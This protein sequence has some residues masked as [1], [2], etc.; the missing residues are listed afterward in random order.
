MALPAGTRLG[1][2]EILS[3]LGSGGMGEVYKARDTRLDRTVAIKVLPALSQANADV[4]ERFEREARVLASLDHPHIC[5]LHDVGNQG[6]VDFLVMPFLT[7]DTL[8]DRLA[9]GPLPIA[10]AIQT[11]TEIADALDR[12]HS[13]GIVHRDLKPGNI[14]LTGSGAKLLDFGLAR[15]DAPAS[16]ERADEART[17]PAL[18]R[19]GTVMGTLP[20]MSP[21]QLTAAPV[22]ARADIW[23][24]GCVLYEMITGRLPFGGD[25]DAAM[26]SAILT[27]EPASVATLAPRAP[28]ALDAVIAGAL[29]KDPDAR[30]QSARDVRR[31]LAMADSRSSETGPMPAHGG[32]WRR[33]ALPIA[34]LLALALGGAAW[35][36]PRRVPPPSPVRFDVSPAG[37]G[38]IPTFTD[39]RPYFAAAP[40]GRQI[41]FV[42]TADGRTDLWVKRLDAEKAERL[43][44]TQN[45]GAPFWSPDGR[46]IAFLANG[47]LKRKGLDGGTAQT[48]CETDAQGINASWNTSG[49][50]LFAEWGTRRI[51]RVPEHGGTPVVVREGENPFGWVQFLPD[52]RHFLYSVV[53]LGTSISHQFVGRLDG[54]DDVAIPEVNS[55]AEFAAGHLVF[56]AEGSL[57]ARPFDPGALRFTGPAVPVAEDVHAFA[58][59]GFAAFSVVQNLLVYQ[60][61]PFNGRLVWLDRQGLEL[62]KVGPPGDFLL[63]RLSPDGSSFAVSARDP[64]L[65]SADILV[66]ELARDFTRRLTSDRG[67]ENG[68]I[69]SPDGKT[70]VYAADRH[71]APN[72]HARAA[73]G[74]GEEREILAP[75][76]GGPHSAGS[77]T[78][79]GQ[80]I[81]FL[82]VNPGTNYDVMLMPIDGHTPPVA[83]VKTKGR[84]TS[85][86]LS[87]DGHWLAYASSESGRSEVYV[88]GFPDGH[89][90]RQISRDGGFD[91][92]WRGDSKELYYIAGPATDQIMAVPVATSGNQIEPSAPR[93]LF[94]AHA[95]VRGYDVTRDGA[96]FLV[97]ASDPAAERGTLSVVTQWTPLLT[98]PVAPAR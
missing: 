33:L 26:V 63:P 1:P 60:S 91:V 14:I 55:R 82:Q 92:R 35:F 15:L 40:D 96:R 80:S 2:Y 69:W 18:T 43:A 71:G 30:W 90:R 72:L 13:H 78:A 93:L 81:V 85:P 9:K 83:I 49:T 97:I 70:I 44:D 50:I 51:L 88:Q 94:V 52:D 67:T 57:V 39:I 11:A 65:G 77:F 89:G 20:Y 31:A 64:R 19:A 54:P 66:H 95:T 22:D 47:Q 3:P 4:R 27:S 25:S 79:D 84:E 16:S 48:I 98:R 75:T 45:A 73:D 24:F 7:G 38:R 34:G 74:T 6:G 76:P 23:A 42:A 37:I 10:Q 17:R 41:A 61:G 86:R 29:A 62:G 36:A 46:A 59:T 56:W 5:A 28:R 53:D 21:E 58:V 12:A 68:P 8:S 87:P 32:T